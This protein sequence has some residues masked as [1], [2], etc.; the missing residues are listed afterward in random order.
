MSF[1]KLALAIFW[2]HPCVVTGLHHLTVTIKKSVSYELL[3][4][5]NT[6]KLEHDVK[7]L[8]DDTAIETISI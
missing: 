6:L 2:P 7:H 8:G 3:K 1:P 4:Y 5:S